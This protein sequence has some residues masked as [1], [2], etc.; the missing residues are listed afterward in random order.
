MLVVLRAGVAA[1]VTDFP[2]V[3]R[4]L[5]AFCRAAASRRTGTEECALHV[6]RMVS[7]FVG[8]LADAGGGS[9]GKTGL[10]DVACAVY[11]DVLADTVD[12]EFHVVR[13]AAVV[14][15]DAL[16]R[17]VPSAASLAEVAD[18]DANGGSGE[19]AEY[20]LCLTAVADRLTLAPHDIALKVVDRLKRAASATMTG[21]QSAGAARALGQV[22][23][24]RVDP[25]AALRL[26]EFVSNLA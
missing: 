20:Y 22:H 8:T 9:D 5:Q 18:Y 7:A 21:I 17:V 25:H 1:E 11:H 4:R 19:E 14:R 26:L 24:E 13:V 3:W 12:H 23:L 15:M 6:V 2:P 16:L 10:V